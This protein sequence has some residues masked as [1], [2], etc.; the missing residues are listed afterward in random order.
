MWFGS[1]IPSSPWAC[2]DDGLKAPAASEPSEA[3]IDPSAWALSRIA[4]PDRSGLPHPLGPLPDGD[5]VRVLQR[6][7]TFAGDALARLRSLDAR[8]AEMLSALPDGARS[9]RLRNA[10][11]LALNSAWVTPASLGEALSV[12]RQA[13]AAMLREL[14]ARGWVQNVQE[15]SRWKVYVAVDLKP[16]RPLPKS[17][18]NVVEHLDHQEIEAMAFSRSDFDAAGVDAALDDAID[19]VRQHLSDDPGTR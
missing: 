19:A 16:V 8:R 4:M 10:A 3:G 6:A 17:P 1:S 18:A 14:E 12:S 2:S 13:S 5:R 7:E 15:R 11:D 9:G